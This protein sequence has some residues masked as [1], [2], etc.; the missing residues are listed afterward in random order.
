MPEEK[1][2]W[3]ETENFRFWLGGL[4]L[5]DTMDILR[6]CTSFYDI[7]RHIPTFSDIFRRD[8]NYFLRNIDNLR[9]NIDNLRRNTDTQIPKFSDIFR[10]FPTFFDKIVRHFTI[11]YDKIQVVKCCG[12]LLGGGFYTYVSTFALPRGRYFSSKLVLNL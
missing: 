2:L 5:D 1:I 12:Q 11:F 6:H 7:F 9:R 10:H 3:G 4:T 8:I